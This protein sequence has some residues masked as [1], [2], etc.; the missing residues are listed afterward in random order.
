MFPGEHRA[1]HSAVIALA[2]DTL[3]R[4][5]RAGG[6]WALL[7]LGLAAGWA[8]FSLAILALGEVGTQAIAV[9]TSTTLTW[10]VL[11][12]LQ[13]LSR[14][15]AH[16]EAATLTRAVDACAPGAPGRWVG[17]WM[18]AVATGVLAGLLLGG[19]LVALSPAPAGL[20]LSLY[21]TTFA[22][23]LPATA[24]GLLLAAVGGAR[25]ALGGGL[26]AW[27][28]GHLPWGSAAL[29]PGPAGRTVAALLPGPS[30]GAAP[31]GGVLA[32]LGLVALALAARTLRQ[33]GLHA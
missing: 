27:V 16:D 14:A 12:G 3:R 2:L 32:A 25:L 28:L 13:A 20:L 1:Y 30:A 8:G 4:A 5:T 15:L 24:W 10:S 31:V 11:L 18:G 7:G 17:R 22:A 9:V 19:L 23:V 29:L 6:S 33:D 21:L 26:L